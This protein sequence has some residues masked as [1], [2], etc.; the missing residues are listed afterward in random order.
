MVNLKPTDKKSFTIVFTCSN[1]T[2]GDFY[3]DSTQKATER[4]L[5]ELTL[6]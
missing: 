5:T 3:V 6:R 2:A 4:T 1:F